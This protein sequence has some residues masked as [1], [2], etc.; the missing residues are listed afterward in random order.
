MK[1]LFV[2]TGN[3]CRSPMAE[4]LFRTMIKTEKLDIDEISSAGIN[5]IPDQYA[6]E[7]AEE[8]MHE[9]GIDIEPH[10]S[11]MLTIKL[12]EEYDLILTMTNS[13]KESI[14]STAPWLDRKAFTLKEY[15][16]LTGDISDPF[17]GSIEVYR[18]SLND[19]EDSLK[20]LIE[21]LKKEVLR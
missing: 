7:N 8:V 20:K 1:I 12:T 10:R 14:L 4:N 21:K 11:Q 3:T 16:G 5:A 19:I 15:V 13:H 17:G 18:D 2:C 6:S 9:K